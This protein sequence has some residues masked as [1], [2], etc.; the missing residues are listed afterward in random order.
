[1]DNRNEL[2]L[3]PREPE[4]SAKEKCSLQ[5]MDATR[6]LNSRKT[7]EKNF[8]F[9]A[10]AAG[11]MFFLRI[12]YLASGFITTFLLTRWLGA[13]NFGI[14][15]FV[16]SYVILTV[17][18]V[19]FGFED[20]L[21]RESAMLEN[22]G[23]DNQFSQLW[24]FSILFVA[25]MSLVAFVIYGFFL[26]LWDFEDKGVEPAFWIALLIIPLRSILG[27]FQGLLRGRKFIILSQIPE[28]ILAPTLTIV[29][30]FTI[31]MLSI[32]GRA[33]YAILVNILVVTVSVSFCYLAS[34]KLSNDSRPKSSESFRLSEL[35]TSSW[36]A[37]AFPFV[38]IAGIHIFNQRTDRLMLGAIQDMES[39]G[40]YSVAVQLS[41]VVNLPLLG[42]TAAIGPLV[43]ERH[44]EKRVGELQ[45]SLIMLTSIAT[46]IAV[47]IVGALTISGEYILRFFDPQF[48]KG[49]IPLLILAVGQLA[50]VAAGP[51]GAILSMS[52]HE[53]LVAISVFIS[54]VMNIAL[55]AT[56]IPTWG[57]FGAAVATTISMICWNCLLLVFA[58]R[59]LGISSCLGAM[60]IPSPLPLVSSTDIQG[61]SKN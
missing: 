2:V 32:P 25:L 50:N 17:I 24:K 35:P 36:V 58:K 41:T 45:S 34:R 16:L 49:F 7:F 14:Y 1:M 21:T 37:G 15:N 47:L 8:Q 30:I 9:I 3:N 6:S 10:K 23:R 11:G 28:H 18:L 26:S 4:H 20:F 56:L 12:F 40:I 48:S 54:A 31:W 43:A 57:L 52:K 29:T 59:T 39:V 44:K 33:E 5:N 55:N 46:I 42:I 61:K 38:L 19:K 53:N 27:L 51:A 13:A 60:L 22:D